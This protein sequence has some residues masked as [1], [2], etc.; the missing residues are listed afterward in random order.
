MSVK[1]SLRSRVPLLLL[2]V[3]AVLTVVSLAGC[4]GKK[5]IDP[6]VYASLRAITRG[7]TLSKG[8]LFEIDAPQFEYVKGNTGIVRDGNLLEFV[9]G[10][11]LEQNHRG[12]AGARLGVQKLFTPTSHLK[13]RRIKRGPEVSMLDSNFAYVVPRV[14]TLSEDDARTPGAPLPELDWKKI[15]DAKNYMP[16]EEGDQP[17]R[18]QSVVER[19]VRVPRHD[20]TEAQKPNPGPSDYAWYAVFPN[21]AL[22]IVELSPGAEWM[23]ELLRAQNK[24]M[25]GSFSLSE[26]VE[27][28][29]DRK[30]DHP[31]IGHVIGKMHVNWFKYANTA[32]KGVAD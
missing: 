18:V 17:I 26:V 2:G 3:L 11:D 1:R 24:P 8:F 10:K 16:K 13:L 9:V 7:D 19:F 29:A 14:I 6:Y 20:L 15:E 4:G 30:T 28:Y 5:E 31:I 12:Y 25:I 21:A 32:V 27:N 22:E 23:F